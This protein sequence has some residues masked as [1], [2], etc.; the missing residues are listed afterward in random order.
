[1]VKIEKCGTGI[2]LNK[3]IAD[4]NMSCKWAKNCI[5]GKIINGIF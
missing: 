5:Y 4:V 2:F 1:M 3:L